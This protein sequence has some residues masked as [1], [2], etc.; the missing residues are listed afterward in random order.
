MNF[1][2]ECRF[3]NKQIK[4]LEANIPN[5]IKKTLI[6]NKK[7]VTANLK[8]LIDLGVTNTYNIFSNYYDMFLM[9][10]SN[11]VE[12]FNKYEESD[13]IDKLNKNVAII[14]YL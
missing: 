1:L 5:T 12:I 13:L 14:E 8:Y 2:E 9:D 6:E 10:Y 7:L 3:T 11:F 4:E